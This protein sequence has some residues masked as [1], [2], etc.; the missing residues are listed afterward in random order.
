MAGQA[1]AIA[2]L[3]SSIEVD[4]SRI[5]GSQGGDLAPIPGLQ[6]EGLLN[7]FDRLSGAGVSSLNMPIT[8]VS[9]AK[10]RPRSRAASSPLYMDQGR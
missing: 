4:G 6:M 10:A 7:A 3:A 1:E 5:A 2:C 8:V 9:G